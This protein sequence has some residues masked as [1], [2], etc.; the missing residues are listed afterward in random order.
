MVTPTTIV[1][2]DWL[3]NFRQIFWRKFVQFIR[4]PALICMKP[5]GGLRDT[6]HFFLGLVHLMFW[7]IRLKRATAA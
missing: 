5:M 1:P 7:C 3:R 4:K 6:F 2:N